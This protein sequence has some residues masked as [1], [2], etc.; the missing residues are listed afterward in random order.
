MTARMNSWVMST[1]MLAYCTFVRLASFLMVMKSSISGWSTRRVSINAP[2]RPA[3][4]TAFVL[5]DSRFMKAVQPG[6]ASTVAFTV[7]PLGRRI[8][9]SVPTPPPVRKTMADSCRQV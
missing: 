8:D 5:S 1:L 6:E 3:C 2:R 7:A 4:D 9:R